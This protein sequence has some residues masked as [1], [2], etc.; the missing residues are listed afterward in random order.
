M[1]LKVIGLSVKPRLKIHEVT[2]TPREGDPWGD[3]RPKH[4]NTLGEAMWPDA[5]K[6]EIA[7]QFRRI[8]VE[9]PYRQKL[10]EPFA[11]S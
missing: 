2:D 8:G 6:E 7:Q 3:L 1:L 10:V 11:T 4:L 9:D 5:V